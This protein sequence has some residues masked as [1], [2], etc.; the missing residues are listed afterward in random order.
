MVI[1]AALAMMSG[2]EPTGLLG[3]DL[4]LTA[5]LASVMVW[6]SKWVSPFALMVTA[7]L[8]LLLSL[9]ALPALICAIT[10]VITG[11]F[12]TVFR[13][14]DR[15]SWRIGA[16]LTTGF[17]TIA[18]LSLP[19]LAGFN[20]SASI[21]AALVITPTVISA[22]ANMP[23][24][25][26][27][28][29][30]LATIAIATLAALAV[31]GVAI[32]GLQAK[33]HVEL[34]IEQANLG[35]TQVRHGL[36]TESATTLTASTQNFDTAYDKL[37]GPLTWP[38]RAVPVL[39][40]HVDAIRMAAQQGS[41]LTEAAQRAL[42]SAD[43]SQ[44]LNSNS[45]LDLNRIA[46]IN[47][48]LVSS[49]KALIGAYN[50][51]E[52]TKSPWLL[53][54]LDTQIRRVQTQLY[55]IHADLAL[56]ELG[57]GVAPGFL[58]SEGERIYLVLFLQPA[59]AR[60]FGGFVGAYGILA[61]NQGQ[62][63]LVETG[64]MGNDYAISPATLTDLE[65]F[66]RAYLDQQPDRFPQNITGFSDL[67]TIATA[68]RDLS[69]QWRNDPNLEIDAVITVDPYAIAALLDLVGPVTI[70]GYET[71]LDSSNAVDF[72]LREQYFSDAETLERHEALHSL[73]GATF[74]RLLSNELPSPSGFID[75]FEP[76]AGTHHIAIAS[77]DEAERELFGRLA[78]DGALPRLP[79]EILDNIDVVGVFTATATPSKLDAYAHR[80]LAYNVTIDPTSGDVTGQLDVTITNNAPPDASDYVTGTGT[81]TMVGA[82]GATLGPAHNVVALS[83]YLKNQPLSISSPPQYRYDT[84]V[85]TDT[86]FGY[87]W[88]K[89]ILEV[90]VN[91]PQVITYTTE[92]STQP[93]HYELMVLT[94][95][96]ANPVDFTL[97]I[98]V[99][100][101]WIIDQSGTNNWTSSI[102]LERN[103]RY[104][105][106]ITPEK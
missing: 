96:T 91:T 66:P 73:A 42:V 97:D 85:D 22:L 100:E 74:E 83:T 35:V 90:P 61:A 88:S 49:R 51:L 70:Q 37:N 106:Q 20:L 16:A 43:L 98:S 15:P 67:P 48:E 69:P 41:V 18:A 7:A 62:I 24:K 32:A 40:Q 50:A 11:L 29:T 47:T 44:I 8:S 33:N 17:S 68:I 92:A 6:F 57:T 89:V 75:A 54:Q 38:A 13:R 34:A 105:I 99:P 12:I 4:I 60:E 86:I 93:G 81:S 55:D 59:E 102:Q 21:S 84:E 28:R 71:P 46:A 87:E 30:W 9:L 23:A 3:A 79:Q 39:A 27:V 77:F 58:G 94:Q 31:M 104:S 45:Q 82:D 65:R 103:T 10:A 63:S 5:T 1:F 2:Q 64:S 19:N 53:P 52:G 26:R 72:L 80:D 14:L 95:A 25:T 78:I 56:A 76:L 36:S 101:G